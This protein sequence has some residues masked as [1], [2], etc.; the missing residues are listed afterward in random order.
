MKDA[1]GRFSSLPK[2]TTVRLISHIDADGIASASIA[3][4]AVERDN[5]S[6]LLSTV[7]QLSAE[8]LEKLSK[9]DYSVYI[10]TDL[11]SGQTKDIAEKLAGRSVF[12]LDHHDIPEQEFNSSYSNLVFVNPRLCGIDGGKEIS[13]AGVAYLFAKE[14]DGRN[15][16]LAHIAIIGAIGDVQ[17]NKGFLE[18]NNAI[19]EDAMQEGLIGVRKGLRLYG[20]QTRA[21]HKALEYSSDPFIPGV[22]GSESGAFQLLNEAGIDPRKG[23]GW[24]TIAELSDEEMQKLVASVVL[25]RAGEADPD[26]VIGY[27]YTLLNEKNG[28]SLRDAKEFST[29]LNACGRLGVT[30]MGIGACLG[31]KKMK[32]KA[33]QM[34]KE[35]KREIVTAMNWFRE[36][37]EMPDSI[38]KGKNYLIVNAQKKVMSTMIGTMLSILS[39]SNTYPEGMFMLGLA[40]AEKNTTKISLRIAGY[41]NA[42][43]LTD[44]MRRITAVVGGEAGGH[45]NAAGAMISSDSEQRFIEASK[46]VFEESLG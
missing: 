34:H 40:R 14:L 19:L 3:I 32:Q 13:G 9:E 31:D 7:Q 4:R 37:Q 17:E 8:V 20:I 27:F 11:G 12:I 45:M 16:D 6:Y 25:R 18:I 35:Y 38:I 24:R 22:S 29:L 44:I 2:D 21:I 26:D 39:K 23:S 30:S 1:A 10:F 33:L 42:V 15:R 43:D 36:N 28:S 46:K 41:K 5:R